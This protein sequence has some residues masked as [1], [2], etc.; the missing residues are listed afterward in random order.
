[1]NN[2]R[3]GCKLYVLD[4]KSVRTRCNAAMRVFPG[5]TSSHLS[6]LDLF[7]SDRTD[8]M[9]F[10]AETGYK[11]VDA[12]IAWTT[13]RAQRDAEITTLNA[14]NISDVLPSTSFQP[15]KSV[16]VSCLLVGPL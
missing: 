6:V 13:S 9:A 8:P 14:A 15:P 5:R 12:A 4:M 7:S 11:R 3:L 10:A 16:F 1:M 2:R